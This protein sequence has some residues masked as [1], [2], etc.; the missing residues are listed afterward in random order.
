MHFF[1]EYFLGMCTLFIARVKAKN[2]VFICETFGSGVCIVEL[3]HSISVLV[4][5]ILC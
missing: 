2:C 1:V 3:A 4:L 5:R